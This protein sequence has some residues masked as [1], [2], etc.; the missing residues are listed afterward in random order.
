MLSDFSPVVS[1]GNYCGE[2]G[3]APAAAIRF[4]EAFGNLPGI[5]AGDVRAEIDSGHSS[6]GHVPEEDIYLI[7]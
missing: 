5:S 4:A 1:S 2:G 3:V 7:P 6:P